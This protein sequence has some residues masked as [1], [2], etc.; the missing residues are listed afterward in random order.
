VRY[1]LVTPFALQKDGTVAGPRT[2]VTERLHGINSI[3]GGEQTP[4]GQVVLGDIA[5]V[6]KLSDTMSGDTLAPRNKPVVVP[7]IRW[8]EPVLSVGIVARTQ[9]D[10]DKLADALHRLL[11][12]DPTLRLERSDE[13]HQMVLGGL[14][15]THLRITMDRLQR[16]FGVAVDTEDVRIAYRET[17]AGTAEAEGKHKK[18][19]GG[20]GQ[21]GVAFL[22]VEP[23]PRG[24]GFEFVDAIVG[25][26][27]PRQFI[28]AVEKGIAETMES[29]GALGFPVVD[30]RVTCYDGKYHSVDSDEMSFKTAGR[31]GF[32]AACAEAEPVLLEPISKLEV[33]VPIEQ[34][35][36]VMGDLNARRGRVQGTE[37]AT[38]NEQTIIAMVPT[39]ELLRYAI[40]L[41]SISGGRGRFVA[42]HD[43]Y[44]AVPAN[45]VG[46]ILA[47]NT[48]D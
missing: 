14:G 33:T 44:D 25:G 9:A 1:Y 12:E 37:S 29:G 5:A 43:H 42:R 21:Y 35:G 8:P 6:S 38:N 15:E 46:A 34:Q 16:K 3:R 32:R 13:T 30:V 31:V 24:D 4:V 22:R 7:P 23:M 17:I 10:D 45:L 11:D 47:A 20:R 27:I 48:S 39:S 41:R 18:Q 26:A 28:P 40:D 19:S 2:G 36:D